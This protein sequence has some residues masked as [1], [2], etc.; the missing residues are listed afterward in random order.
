MA[1]KRP[2]GGMGHTPILAPR[3]RPPAARI[4]PGLLDRLAGKYL[5]DLSD[6]VGALYTVDSGIRPL[7]Q[8]VPRLVGQALTVK[9]PP[10]DNLTVHMALD[11]VEDGDVLV[12]D[13]RG[14]TDACGTG[15]GA[16]VLPTSKGLRGVVVDGGWRDMTEVRGLNLPMFGRAVSPFSPPKKRIGDINVPVSCGGV[17]VNPGDLLVGDDDGLVVIPRDAAAHV[18]DSVADYAPREAFD[19]WPLDDLRAR[20]ERIRRYVATVRDQVRPDAIWEY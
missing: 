8:P 6:A 11:M 10:G 13:W 4:D 14:H 9:A 12:L 7:Y 19:Q 17:V 20:S 2:D 15:G 5:P 16:L 3:I 1:E 18:V